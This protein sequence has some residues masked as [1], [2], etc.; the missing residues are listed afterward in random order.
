MK[1]YY[2]KQNEIYTVAATVDCQ[3]YDANGEFIVTC[4]ANRSVNVPSSTNKL[5]LSDNNAVLKKA[6]SES[7]GTSVAC[8]EH[9]ENTDIHVTT[10]EKNKISKSAQLNAFNSFTNSNLFYGVVQINQGVKVL[11]L[12]KK[13]I[14]GEDAYGLSVSESGGLQLFGTHFYN[15]D[16]FTDNS[17]KIVSNNLSM[18]STDE[19]AISFDYAN[20][21]I[22]RSLPNDGTEG[23]YEFQCW[24]WTN[25][26][27]DEMKPAAVKLLKASQVS[28]LEDDSVLNKAECDGLYA[29]LTGNNT[30]IAGQTFNGGITCNTGTFN[31]ALYKKTQSTQLTENAVLN[32]T[33]LDANYAPKNLV[34]ANSVLV[35]DA[36]G[37][38]SASSVSVSEL[39]ALDGVESNVQTQLDKKIAFPDYSTSITGTTKTLSQNSSSAVSETYSYTATQNVYVFIHARMNMG[40]TNWDGSKTSYYELKVRVNDNLLYSH[41]T[42]LFPGDSNNIPLMLRAGDTLSLQFSATSGNRS[43]VVEYYAYPLI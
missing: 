23:T 39:N 38:V 4:P 25:G 24:Q 21:S 31:A 30:F 6:V 22:F 16:L 18:Y 43:G 3:V 7:G 34:N 14:K 1:T 28:E 9:I 11:P 19:A 26:D 15:K 29:R 5:S 10:D 40:S 32:K 12:G 20:K 8:V 42:T 27:K 2:V 41:S 35:T 17:L 33:E 13:T 36:S 37:N